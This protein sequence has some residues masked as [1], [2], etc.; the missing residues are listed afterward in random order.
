VLKIQLSA[1]EADMDLSIKLHD[2]YT[3]AL[4]MYIFPAQAI[5]DSLNISGRECHCTD[6]T[7]QMERWRSDTHTEIQLE[8]ESLASRFYEI[9]KAFE[10]LHK[11]LLKKWKKTGRDGLRRV[12]D[13]QPEQHDLKSKA[14]V[15]KYFPR[16]IREI[17]E[18]ESR[19]IHKP[20][21][22]GRSD[23]NVQDR[24]DE[25]AYDKGCETTS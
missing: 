10:K 13:A 21:A 17:E 20:T 7:R 24:V 3:A 2:M 25:E 14:V 5:I 9:I 11:D 6:C 22:V 23:G 16:Q 19:T 1:L 18:A 4:R 12:I 15:R 8:A